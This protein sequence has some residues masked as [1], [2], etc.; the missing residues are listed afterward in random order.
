MSKMKVVEKSFV[1]MP[2]APDVCQ[3][4]AVKHDPTFPHNAHSL[5][6]QYKFHAA[7]G[8]WPTWGDAMA[9][10][11]EPMKDEWKRHLIARGVSTERFIP[12]RN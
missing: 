10:C 3:E 8:L 6:Y 12:S 9:H 7:Y 1:L 4:C 5:H 11:S 2:C